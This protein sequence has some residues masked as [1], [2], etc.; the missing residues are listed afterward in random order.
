MKPKLFS[1]PNKM[2]IPVTT[3]GATSDSFYTGPAPASTKVDINKTIPEVA[4]TLYLVLTDHGYY[5][6]VTVLVTLKN[7]ETTSTKSLLF[8]FWDGD[9]VQHSKTSSVAFDQV[10]DFTATYNGLSGIV[11]DI[12]IQAKDAEGYFIDVPGDDST[13]YTYY[14]C[15]FQE[16]TTKADLISYEVAGVAIENIYYCRSYIELNTLD[17]FEIEGYTKEVD[18]EIVNKTFKV[19]SLVRKIRIPGSNKVVAYDFFAKEI[20]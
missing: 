16:I 18:G 14:D 15:F 2:I 19:Y 13:T 10:V 1:M 3:G 20:I 4:A 8:D 5:N 6:T 7:G 11:A 9:G 12:K 17:Q